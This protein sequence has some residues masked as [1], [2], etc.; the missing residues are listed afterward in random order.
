MAHHRIDIEINLG[1]LI[2]QL[3]RSVQQ[4][5]SLVGAG[6]RANQY[7]TSEP[8]HLPDVNMGMRYD[9]P[10]WTTDQTQIEYERFGVRSWILIFQCSLPS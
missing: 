2:N 5:I 1:G 8:L 10:V 3:S 7:V 9:K 4:T 6:L